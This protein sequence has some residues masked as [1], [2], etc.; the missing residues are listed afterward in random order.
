MV[1][2][3]ENRIVFIHNYDNVLFSSVILK[4]IPQDVSTRYRSVDMTVFAAFAISFCQ[5]HCVSLC[6]G[7][8]APEFGLRRILGW[9]AGFRLGVFSRLWKPAGCVRIWLGAFGKAGLFGC[10]SGIR[11]F[12]SR[13][14]ISQGFL[15]AKAG[16][17]GFGL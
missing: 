3:L 4:Y 1:W 17:G 6:K 16:F 10:Q 14:L 5:R 11:G 7:T 8:K 2:P 13:L 12:G 15:G 9:F